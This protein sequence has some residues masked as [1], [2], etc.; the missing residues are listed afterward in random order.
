MKNFKTINHKMKFA[1]TVLVLIISISCSDAQVNQK[2][3]ESVPL[4]GT[5]PLQGLRKAHYTEL[6]PSKPLMLDGISTPVY[7]ENL[8]LIQ[9]EDFMKVMS[10]G[11]YFPDIY[12]DSNKEVKAF[13]LRKATE[14]EKSKMVSMQTDAEM[15]GKSDLIGKQALPFSVT[16]INGNNYSLESLKGKIIVINFWFVECK[17]CV[18]E[19]PELNKLVEK[20]NNKE[21]VFLGFALNEKN[22]IEKFL[23]TTQYKYNIIA[24]A[25]EVVGT[26]GVTSFPTHIVI[27]KNSNI[28]LELSG[29][30]PTTIDELDKVIS[31]L[32][33]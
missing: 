31:T 28:V 18:M 8:T 12:I 7:T 33:N 20:Y 3:N 5:N 4:N 11:D 15:P 23:K 1:L 25:K 6:D 13:V 19:M 29:L 16:D 2:I 9:G 21:V 17:P 24:A 30:G 10:N 26:Y 27:D 32:V 22:K 14:L